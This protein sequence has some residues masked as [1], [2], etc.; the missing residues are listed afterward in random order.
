MVKETKDERSEKG[1]NR[2]VLKF[3]ITVFVINAKCR[4][5][6]CKLAAMEMGRTRGRGREREWGWKVEKHCIQSR[7]GTPGRNY[8]RIL[9]NL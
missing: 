4:E 5:G 3:V 2:E 7:K 8:R 6:F 9:T 1:L